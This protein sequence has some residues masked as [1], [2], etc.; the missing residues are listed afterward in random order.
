M[1]KDNFETIVGVTSFTP[2]EETKKKLHDANVD[3]LVRNM[4]RR[5]YLIIETSKNKYGAN[6]NTYATSNKE[7]QQLFDKKKAELKSKNDELFRKAL[8]KE[9]NSMLNEFES[10]FTGKEQAIFNEDA[11]ALTKFRDWLNNVTFTTGNPVTL[12]DETFINLIETAEKSF[13]GEGNIKETAKAKSKIEIAAFVDILYSKKYI[14]NNKRT[15]IDVK[16]CTAFA[17]NRY[18]VDLGDSITSAKRK[19]RE[20]HKAQML[21]HFK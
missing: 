11:A 6:V 15:G 10:D 16:A 3:R 17:A 1:R 19:D 2:V 13:F 12:I 7:F 8:L 14:V 5:D 9:I 4:E 20:P 18:K 21:K